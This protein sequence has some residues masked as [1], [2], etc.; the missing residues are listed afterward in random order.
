MASSSTICCLSTCH[1]CIGHNYIGHSDTGHD[2]VGKLVYDL[3]PINAS[4]GYCYGW[5]CVPAARAIDAYR[6]FLHDFSAFRKTVVHSI[7]GKH[8]PYGGAEGRP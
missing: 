7:L 8:C 2:Y 3:L 1:D 5:S 6:A 4:R